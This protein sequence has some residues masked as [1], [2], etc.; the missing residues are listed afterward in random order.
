MQLLEYVLLPPVLNVLQVDIVSKPV[1]IRHTLKLDSNINGLV[2]TIKSNDTLSILIPVFE[3]PFHF[4]LLVLFNLNILTLNG[5]AIHLMFAPRSNL[6]DAR[7]LCELA[8][9]LLI[10]QTLV[11]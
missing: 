10:S 7:R 4:Y 5:V 9:S 8:Q 2:A 11:D 6:C 1:M 3:L